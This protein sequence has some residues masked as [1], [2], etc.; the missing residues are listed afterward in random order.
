MKILITGGTGDVGRALTDRLARAGHELIV[1]GRRDAV[2][3]P[4]ARYVRCEIADFDGLAQVA[5]GC[6]AIFHLAAIRAPRMDTGPRIFATNGAGTYN[7]YEAAAVNGI[8]RV[9][10]AS[11]IN[12]LGFFFGPTEF[13]LEYLPIDEE[14]PTHTTDPYSFSKEITERIGRYYWRR[15]GI[16][17]AMLRLP[18]VHP[19]QDREKTLERLSALRTMAL[20][21]LAKPPC[22]QR[23]FMH[24]V[25]LEGNRFRAARPLEKEQNN[26]QDGQDRPGADAWSDPAHRQCWNLRANF[27]T[28]IDDRDS[29]E[30]FEQALVAEYDGAPAVFVHDD[31]NV[32]GLPSEAL[33]RLFYPDVRQRKKAFTASEALITVEKARRLFGFQPRYSYAPELSQNP[34]EIK[35]SRNS[36]CRSL[37]TS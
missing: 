6:D 4:G 36:L 14:H 24:Q 5:T 37:Q 16:S 34:Q 8:R 3:I 35:G 2:S 12:A 18:G 20:E 22:D 31:Q 10:T 7:V 25:L 33:A 30:A 23:A 27:F 17:G 21:W 26:R 9:V 11:S 29:A 19:A 13:P 1:I 32:L 15:E 28:G